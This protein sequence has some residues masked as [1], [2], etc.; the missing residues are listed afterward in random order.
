MEVFPTQNLVPQKPQVVRI[1]EGN[2]DYDQTYFPS[3]NPQKTI[4]YVPM[5]QQAQP[6]NNNNMVMFGTIAVVIVFFGFL[7]FI[8][9][10]RRP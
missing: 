3:R 9:A 4:G 1:I 6:S 8:L 10:L 7:G 5:I 2:Y